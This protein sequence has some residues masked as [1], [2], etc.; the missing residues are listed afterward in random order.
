[1]GNEL[2]FIVQYVLNMGATVMLPIIIF[3]LAICFRVKITKAIRS[4]IT[5]GVGFVGIY[6][7]FG[8]LSSSLGPATQALVANTGINL[9]VV[10]LGWAPLSAITW[11]CPIAPFVIF[12][13]L[14]LNIAM[15]AFKLTK[16]I[17]IDIWN[18]WHFAFAGALVYTTTGS[19]VLG[20]AASMV[21]AVVIIKIADWS[22]PAV[23]KYFNLPGISLPTLSSAVF[24]PVGLLGDMII[25]K[26]PGL[27]K[28][29]ADPQS[30]QKRFGVFGEP[31]MIGLI[32]GILLGIAAG[33]PVNK[34][35]GLGMNLAAVMLILPRMARILME[36]LIPLS[37]SI[38]AIL[39][40]RYPNSD[41]NFTI[42][43]DIAVAIGNPAV[44]STG[45]LLTPV[46]VLLAVIIPGN[47]ILPLADLSNMAV[48]ISMVVLATRGNVVR[49]FLIGIPIMVGDL[50]VA[51]K[52]A[53]LVTSVAKS[54]KFKS[55]YNGQISSF[56]D[57]GN[58][59]RFWVVK[60]FEGNIIA[61]VLIPI[62]GAIIWAL[63]KST[64]KQASQA[65]PKSE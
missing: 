64:K 65:V 9:P 34:I 27:N 17:D 45:L 54:I 60:I 12:F 36:G 8:I 26:I 63:V 40:K 11:A 32:L 3:I 48:M 29:K 46:A 6:A 25:E 58:P 15:I 39:K 38:K 4:A 5:V 30:I 19:F 24:Y 13:T 51:S 50:L 23:E 43:L 47:R 44:I 53:P 7:I 22:A 57:G 42:G 31:M 28:L 20:I 49:S 37:D 35:L 55:G 62:I 1:M 2:L 10:D 33:Y 59:F 56:L 21:T 16:T 18:Y 61:I 14:I 52:I 41:G